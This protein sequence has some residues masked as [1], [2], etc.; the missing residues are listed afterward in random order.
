[1]AGQSGGS[2]KKRKIKTSR[3]LRRSS[4]RV[5]LSVVQLALLGKGLVASFV[6]AE[7]KT[8]WRGVGTATT[9]F[10]RQQAELN[11]KLYPHLYDQPTRSTR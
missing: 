2:Q 10:D 11:R 6:P 5:P 1:M 9:P 3:G 8:A 4:L 7:A